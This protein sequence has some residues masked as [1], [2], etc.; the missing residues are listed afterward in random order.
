[1]I[2][3]SIALLVA[4]TASA[5][6]PRPQVPL[7]GN[8]GAGGVFPLLNSGILSFSSDADYT[9]SYPETSAF[10]I[11]VTS[12]I[13]LTATRKLVAP[14]TLGFSFAV[15]NQTSGGQSICVGASTGSCVTI[16]NGSIGMVYCDGINYTATSTAAGI[17]ALTG[18]VSASGTGSVA[19][20]LAM[21]NGSP[22]T[23]GDATHVPQ[24]DVNN[25]GLTTGCT[26]VAISFPGAVT[27]VSV[28]T[29][30]G[31]QGTSSGG[32]TPQLTL[33]VDSTHVLPTNTGI[34]TQ[35]LNGAGGYSTPSSSY[36]LGG[37]L[38]NSNVVVGPNMGTGSAAT[39]VGL[40]GNHQLVVSVTSTATTG[41][42]ATVTFTASRGHTT[43]CT[44]SPASLAS[45]LFTGEFIESAGTDTYYQ[46]AVTSSP[47]PSGNYYFNVSCP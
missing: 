15:E 37:T 36:S 43:Y 47:P 33:N 9:M 45:T 29:A 12:S 25:K 8:I 5:Q 22:G 10:V 24:V 40:D 38:S 39:V 34:T 17:T 44:F 20:T 28:A 2:R 41:I 31:L 27:A 16:P 35:Y 3:L 46:L 21:V 42:M 14:L 13:S 6:V 1:M 18:D 30:N 19:A 26:P 7:T 4:L 23:C 11:K 32:T